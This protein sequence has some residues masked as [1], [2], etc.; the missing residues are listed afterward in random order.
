MVYGFASRDVFPVRRKEKSHA[1]KQASNYSHCKWFP[2][3][4][5]LDGLQ[6]GFDF[7]VAICTIAIGMNEMFLRNIRH[8]WKSLV[9]FH[10]CLCPKFP[11]AIHPLNYDVFPTDFGQV[12]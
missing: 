5:F 2:M 1:Q 4:S 10:C 9:R 6:F 11:P 8:N 3:K 7:S 12:A